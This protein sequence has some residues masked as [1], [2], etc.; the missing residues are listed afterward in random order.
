[1][2]RLDG[3]VAIVTGA[4]R[5]V[6]RLCALG[7]A[8]EGADVVVAAKT[9]E[10]S[11]KLSGTIHDVAGEIEALG[12][13]ALALQLDVRDAEAIE[14]MAAKVAATFGRVD[15]LVNNA[16]AVFLGDAVD[17]PA[18]RYDLMHQVNARAS[19]LCARAVIP[20]MTR[21]GHIVMMSPPIHPPKIA[22]KVAYGMS[23]LGM[24]LCAL[25]LAEELRAEKI[26][27]NALWPVTAVETAAV[28]KNG[29]GEP[30]LWRRPEILADAAVELVCTPPGEKTGLCLYDEDVLG[31]LGIKDFDA[32]YA[33]VPGAIVPPLSKV[34]FE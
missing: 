6:G 2:G 29:F 4:S 9:I 31:W 1:M 19:F 11:A 28:V 17:T 26:S 10:A 8:R 13:R 22:G 24:T 14:A 3:K 30:A 7:F 21:G 32:R 16:G 18:R 23:K 20:F 34:M 25:G 5:G 12:H 27:C 33:C 15:V